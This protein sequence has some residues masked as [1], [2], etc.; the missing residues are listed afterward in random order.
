[1]LSFLDQIKS[2]YTPLLNFNNKKK[3][4]LIIY[5]RFAKTDFQYEKMSM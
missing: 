1:M 2:F 5:E 4:T 3:A